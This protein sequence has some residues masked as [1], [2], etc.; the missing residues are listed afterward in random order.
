MTYVTQIVDTT[1][2]NAVV[3][4]KRNKDFGLNFI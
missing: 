2:F 1:G 4:H 3:N